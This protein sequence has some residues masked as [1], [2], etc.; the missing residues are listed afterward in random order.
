MRERQVRIVNAAWANAITLRFLQTGTYDW[1][2]LGWGKPVT[3]QNPGGRPGCDFL[4][5]NYYGRW[6]TADGH[7]LCLMMLRGSCDKSLVDVIRT[8][9]HRIGAP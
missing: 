4:G 1:P 9:S 3:W 8:W 2:K 6:M 5:I 7:L